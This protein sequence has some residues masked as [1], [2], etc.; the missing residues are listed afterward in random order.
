VGNDVERLGSN[1]ANP[2]TTYSVDKRKRG[3]WNADF[4]KIK[5]HGKNG[6]SDFPC[7]RVL[8][9]PPLVLHGSS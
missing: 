8:V 4:R 6:V 2:E 7:Q 9:D 3:E 5:A 1:L